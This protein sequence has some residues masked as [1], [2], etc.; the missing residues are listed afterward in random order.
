MIASD[1]LE[2][3]LTLWLADVATP[4]DVELAD[5][6][7][8]THSL[9]QRTPW[10]SPAAWRSALTVRPA[11][12]GRRSLSAL[13]LVGLMIGVL[14]A[15]TLVS[16]SRRQLPLPIGPARTGLFAFSTERGIYVVEPDGTGRTLLAS[17][18]QVGPVWSPDGTRLAYWSLADSV[19]QF[20][21]HVVDVG[22]S[23]SIP[24]AGGR[25]FYVQDPAVWSPD[26]KRLA[27]T[28]TTG[29]LRLVNSDGSNLQRIGDPAMRFGIPTWSPD[30]TWIAVRVEMDPG[31]YRG[32]VIHP[33]GTAQTAITAPFG[34]G[35]SH[36]GFGWSP[37]GRSVVYHVSVPTD[38][39]IAIS[40]LDASGAW[41]QE[42]LLDGA[43]NDVLPA[44][45]NDGT[46]I[47]FI[48][49]E[50]LDTSRQVSRLMTA[51]AN[52]ADPRVISD[53]PVDRYV[54][55]WSPDDRSIGVMSYST[56]D[57]LSVV[58]LVAVDGSG[59]IEINEPGGA[60]SPCSWQRLAP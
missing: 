33:D 5:V 29:E 20:S 13:L 53:R 49:I 54:P 42:T 2:R 10:A 44:W 39:D 45:S 21:L 24:M 48:R 25:T 34:I 19:R 51:A 59:V 18:P 12:P 15:V 56:E 47:A 17:G 16:G 4:R 60:F 1:D 7:A 28:T 22:S 57:L 35:E 55:C 27:F 58:D 50:G 52:G 30:G 9:N 26:G 11:A 14:V 46:R 31:M 37:D 8:Q 6:F 32:Y 41:R 40:R 43:N 23:V 3:Q 36:M 38:L